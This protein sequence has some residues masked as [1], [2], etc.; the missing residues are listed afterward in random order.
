MLPRLPA[1]IPATYRDGRGLSTSERGPSCGS[2]GRR[3]PTT[4]RSRHP[5]RTRSPASVPG[6]PFEPKATVIVKVQVGT[7]TPPSRLAEAFPLSQVVLE[8]DTQGRDTPFIRNRDKF[9]RSA[10]GQRI[11]TT[12]STTSGTRSD[13]RSLP[14]TGSSKDGTTRRRGC[15][16]MPAATISRRSRRPTRARPMTRRCARTFSR[17]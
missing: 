1:T 13:S 8:R 16:A 10:R 2:S 11:P 12:S 4:T 5:V 15:A 9:I 6:T 7:I 17:R 3:R 14:G